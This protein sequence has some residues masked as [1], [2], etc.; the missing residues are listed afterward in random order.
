M[1]ALLMRMLAPPCAMLCPGQRCDFLGSVGK[2]PLPPPQPHR[3]QRPHCGERETLDER[4]PLIFLCRTVQDL[5]VHKGLKFK[6]LNNVNLSSF[7]SLFF[8]WFHGENHSFHCK[9]GLLKF[10]IVEPADASDL[11]ARIG[12]A[13][14]GQ[15]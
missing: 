1:T 6:A 8:F 10:R 4:L 12:A 11:N 13:A 15:L 9:T 7:V 5:Q 14:W 2:T 3:Q